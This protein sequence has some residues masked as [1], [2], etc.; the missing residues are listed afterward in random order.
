M[1]KIRIHSLQYFF[2]QKCTPEII[3]LIVYYCCAHIIS[4]QTCFSEKNVEN[5]R[6]KKTDHSS[7]Q[8]GQVCTLNFLKYMA[9]GAEREIAFLSFTISG[10]FPHVFLGFL[11]TQKLV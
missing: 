6:F 1:D 7:I 10:Y 3:K 2:Y 4:K 9:M 11:R 8:Q 5:L